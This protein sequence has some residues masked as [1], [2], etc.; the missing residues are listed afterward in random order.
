[1]RRRVLAVCVTLALV[2]GCDRLPGRP[3][4]GDRPL[5]PSRVMDFAALYGENCAGCHGAEALPG[6]TVALADA[7]Y[8]ALADDA[9]IRRVTA[10][11]VPGTAMPA[12][13]RSAGGAL[14]DEQIDVLVRGMRARW[15][16]SGVLGTSSP[17]PYAG[18]PGDARRGAEVYAAACASCHGPD[19]TGGQRG[20]SIVDGSYLALVS[21]Q[22]LRTAI[23]VGRPALGMPDWRGDQKGKALT[24]DDV[25]DVV[26]WLVARRQKLPGQPYPAKDDRDG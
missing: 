17:P 6:A 14:T 13:A 23:L 15:G 2:A 12:F 20:G 24:A 26:G 4:R 9:T 11:G 18:A 3:Q 21:N 22:G 10:A 7:V 16:R 25:T 5:R 19:G 8:L 1:M